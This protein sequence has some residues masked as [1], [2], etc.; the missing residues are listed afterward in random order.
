MGKLSTWNDQR[1]F[2]FITPSA[3]GPRVFVHISA[4]P[5]G[6]RPALND[7]VTYRV[8]QDAGKRL[9]AKKVLYLRRATRVPTWAPGTMPALGMAVAFFLALLAFVIA[10]VAPMRVVGY[11]ATV[12]AVSFI[13][14]A[15]DKS[16]AKNGARRVAEST[17]H[18]SG[19][20]G[21]WPGAL[22]AQ[23]V[24]RH[25]TRKQP[26]QFLFW[27]TVAVNTVAMVWLLIADGASGLRASFGIG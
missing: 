13:L 7:A 15:L 19:I 18:L 3:G 23:R 11:C 22:V 25:K 1:G 26:F 8:T 2:G 12:S 20:A 5:R 14:Y 4:F 10:G 17:L 21:G 24:F 16:A 6:R 27:I 9:Q